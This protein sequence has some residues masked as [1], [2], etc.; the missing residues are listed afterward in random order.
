VSEGA[1]DLSEHGE[2]RANYHTAPRTVN[3]FPRAPAA[4]LSHPEREIS[5]W[6]D[7]L[8]TPRRLL[9]RPLNQPSRPPGQ[10]SRLPG[11]LSRSPGH[12]NSPHCQFSPPT[13]KFNF[14]LNDFS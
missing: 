8:S 1:L 4:E 11:H 12:L 10:L 7:K 14:G 9:A 5:D 6:I 13:Y 2:R 3:D